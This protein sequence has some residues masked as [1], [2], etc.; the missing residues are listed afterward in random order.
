MKTYRNEEPYQSVMVKFY[1]C[2]KCQRIF[3]FYRREFIEIYSI[4]YD[5]RTIILMIAAIIIRNKRLYGITL[6]ETKD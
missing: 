1:I 2:T 4:V 3:E 5:I 6:I